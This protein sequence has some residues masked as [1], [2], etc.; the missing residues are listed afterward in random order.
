MRNFQR[1]IEG[2]G[3]VT[4][5]CGACEKVFQRPHAHVRGETNACSRSCSHKLHK[6]RPKTMIDCLC[7]ECGKSFQIRKG[8]GGKGMYCSMPCVAKSRGRLISGENHPFWNGGSSIRTHKVRQTII[9]LVKEKGKCE[10]CG[11]I[12]DLQG[13]HIKSHSTEPSLRADPNNIQVLCR[14]CHADKHPRLKSFI[15]AG[16]RHS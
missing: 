2:R 13:H 8:K 5:T 10:E 12:N 15:L 4:L 16:G 9:S 11:E 3:S 7:K 6:K 14:P 1:K